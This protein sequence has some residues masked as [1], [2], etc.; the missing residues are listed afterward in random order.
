[1][2]RKVIVVWRRIVAP[3]TIP[4]LLL[5]AAQSAMT[6]KADVQ[7]T[8]DD[9][10]N[11][12]IRT[13][14][15]GGTYPIAPTT[16][17]VGD[18]A[19]G[20]VPISTVS[21]SLGVVLDGTGSVSYTISTNIIAPTTVYTLMN[22]SCGSPGANIA[23]L[24]FKGASGATAS[25]D[26]IEGTNIR[27]HYCNG[28]YCNTIAAGTPTAIF[29]SVRLDRQTF[30]LPASF[31]SDTLTQIKFTGHASSDPSIGRAFLAAMTVS[32]IPEPGSLTLLALGLAGVLAYAW[33]KCKA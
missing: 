5:V 25:F 24:E 29:D 14:T 33:R 9:L 1:M 18:I 20:L 17:T 30:S 31:A 8:L 12:N 7:V 6:A 19:F 27:D 4:I 32:T 15:S 16:L 22:S 23:T 10:V 13:W 3:A 2:F 11:A 28:I 21:D 26:L